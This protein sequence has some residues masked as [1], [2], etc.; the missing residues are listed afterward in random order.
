MF[1]PINYPHV[2]S[3]S[4]RIFVLSKWNRITSSTNYTSVFGI[5]ILVTV[6]LM[7]TLSMAMSNNLIETSSNAYAQSDNDKNQQGSDSSSSTTT[8][9]EDGVTLHLTSVD[10]APLTNG[11]NNQLKILADYK[12]LD[13]SLV[14]SPMTGTLKVYDKDGKVLK[15]PSIQKGLVLGEAGVAQFATSFTD[16]TITEVK[17]EAYLTDTTGNKISNTLTTDASLSK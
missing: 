14:N 2:L 9:L 16:K 3:M 1:G 8:S 17:A 11:G 6:G 5:S 4:S 12:T 10:F 7:L 13:S 15:T